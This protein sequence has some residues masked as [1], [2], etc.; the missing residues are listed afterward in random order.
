MIKNGNVSECIKEANRF[1]YW[2][3]IVEKEM[4]NS[5]FYWGGKNSASMKRASLDLTRA[6]AKMRTDIR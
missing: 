2:A 6:L 5:A 4:K 3:R 1:I